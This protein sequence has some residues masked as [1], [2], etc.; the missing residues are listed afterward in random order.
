MPAKV[1][2][3]AAARCNL[4]GACGGKGKTLAL[5]RH[6]AVVAICTERVEA[7]VWSICAIDAMPSCNLHGACGGKGDSSTPYRPVFFV[8]ICTERVE[9]K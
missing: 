8:A 6:L 4:H 5:L 1:F 7:K 3:G 2:S 9:A